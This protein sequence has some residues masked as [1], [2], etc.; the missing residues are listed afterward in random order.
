MY[1][2]EDEIPVGW[3]GM[4][5]VCPGAKTNCQTLF[6]LWKPELW[7]GALQRHVDSATL[8]SLYIKYCNN[9]I[10]N[11]MNIT[12]TGSENIITKLSYL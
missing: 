9:I 8:F 5:L 6:H 7:S 2:V 11:C 10:I 1:L 3:T 4:I 12:Y